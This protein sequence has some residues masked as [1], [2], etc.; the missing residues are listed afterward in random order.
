MELFSLYPC[1]TKFILE[2]VKICLH[3][4]SFLNVQSIIDV[5]PLHLPW[6]SGTSDPF[7]YHG[8]TQISTW[9]SN[10]I[11]YNMRGGITYP[12]PN[13]N[14][15]TVEVWEWISNFIPHFTGH[16]ITYPCWN[17][18]PDRLMG[19]CGYTKWY[20]TNSLVSMLT[21]RITCPV[22]HLWLGAL[23]AN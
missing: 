12:L 6:R 7:Y 18:L 16:V 13:F 1:P 11:R 10:H 19:Y 5:G 8:L 23:L 2:N 4:L 17:R 15:A 9:I 21:A 20:C 22:R 14:G 3:I